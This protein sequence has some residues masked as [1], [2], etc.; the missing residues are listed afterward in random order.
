MEWKIRTDDPLGTTVITL[1]AVLFMLFPA[2]SSAGNQRWTSNGPWGGWVSCLAIDA[3]TPTKL[4][5]GTRGGGVFKSRDGGQSWTAIN[6]GLTSAQIVALAIDSPKTERPRRE[7]GARPW[8]RPSAA[9]CPDQLPPDTRGEMRDPNRG[10]D[11]RLDDDRIL[12]SP[13][14][15]DRFD[16]AAQSEARELMGGQISCRAHGSERIRGQIGS[17]S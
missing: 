12:P 8:C 6:S 16:D 10:E 7:D 2:S 15:T 17:K 9:V 14:P 11:V 3:R 5:A 13:P 4:Y 1:V